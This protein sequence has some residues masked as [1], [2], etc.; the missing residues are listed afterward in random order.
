MYN[1]L[2]TRENERPRYTETLN[3]LQYIRRTN[4]IRLSRAHVAEPCSIPRTKLL[5]LFL[6]DYNVFGIPTKQIW[7]NKSIWKA[8]NKVGFDI[9][10]TG[11]GNKDGGDEGGGDEG[12]G[13]EGEG[14]RLY[15]LV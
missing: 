2:I 7:T 5:H 11:K 14:R 9:E 8:P 13:D 6:D 3:I 15:S 12:G 1:I 10:L 4:Y